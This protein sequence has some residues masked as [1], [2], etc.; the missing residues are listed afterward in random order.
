MKKIAILLLVII[1]LSSMAQLT[2]ELKG[3]VNKKISSEILEGAQVELTRIEIKQDEYGSYKVVITCNGIE[4][5]CGLNEIKKISFTPTNSKEFWQNQA[6]QHS[7]YDNIV[8]N[9]LQY[10]LRRELEEEAIE[11]VNYVENNNLCF[12]DS[13]LE[14][15]L[16]AL[17]YRIY[18]SLL[19]DGRPGI[20][21][22]KILKD[23][24][25][26]A[27]I[28][29]NG[30]MFIST[31]LLSTINSEEELIG[32][33]AH[34]ISHFVLDHYIININKAEKRQKRA[35]FWA[36]FATG[37]ALA[38]DVY[39]ATNYEYYAPGAIT[40]STAILAY[41]IAASVNERMGLKYSREQEMEADKCAVELMKYID[42]TPTALASALS[43]IKNYCIITGNYLSLSGEGTHPALED[44][45]SK[46]GKPSSFYDIE[47]DKTIS[48]V[49]SFNAIVEL[50]NKHLSSCVILANRNI[51]A[52]VA[53]EEDYVLLA[54]VTLYMHD[55]ESKNQEAL[56]YINK[57]KSLD[58]YPSINISKQ[59]AIV[60]IRLGKME[61][62]KNSLEKYREGLADERLNL[63][64]IFNTSEWSLL[65]RYIN[66]EYEWTVKMINKV[67]QL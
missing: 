45:I 31:G 34:E 5:S 33:L 44:R 36:S 53:T 48:F 57:A 6:L 67:K 35:E 3:R 32:V 11:Y 38:A 55:T 20:L 15:Y 13:Y 59:E 7:V 25:P 24:S 17:I 14:S 26:N 2:F 50:N 16:Y 41:S 43:K 61:A 8:K 1:P 51:K 42:V 21:N 28:F 10:K 64:K 30:T 65:N 37:V 54:M 4:E 39:A 63:D 19:D 60:L 27:F 46:I 40:M 58:I 52:N 18:P 12:E 56:E 22:V 29:P 66:K 47:Y 9:G 49:N 62:A 23:L